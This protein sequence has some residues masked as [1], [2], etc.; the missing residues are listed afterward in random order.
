MITPLYD[1][2]DVEILGHYRLRLT[3]SDGLIGDV[4][5]SDLRDWGGV[6]TPLRDPAA[7]AQGRA[8]PETGTITWPD[9]ADP[10]P[11]PATSGHQ[12][13]PAKPSAD[14]PQASH[15]AP[16]TSRHATSRAGTP[17]D[18]GARGR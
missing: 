12:R 1:V 7:F 10:R 14:S 18:R 17:H 2:T 9:G 6:F 4:D 5:L 11:K 8:G 15:H 13:T 3:F 16:R